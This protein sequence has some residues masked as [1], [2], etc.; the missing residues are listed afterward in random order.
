[1]KDPTQ[2]FADSA[3]LRRTSRIDRQ[4]LLAIDTWLQTLLDDGSPLLRQTHYFHGRYENLYI[5]G[6]DGT[7]GNGD[8]DELIAEGLDWS[9]QIFDTRPDQLR[10]GFWFNLMQPGQVTTLHRHDDFD[11]MLSGVV[12]LKVPEQSGDLVLVL[13]EREISLPPVMGDFVFFS[14]KTP[15]R[16]EQ[17]RSNSR[18]LSIGM[19][20]GP[21]QQSPAG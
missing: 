1:M 19:N 13:D 11:E 8:L 2:V 14:P 9:A 17:N 4:R 12:Y 20:I 7:T 18:R 16:V 15:H 21:A 3:Y 10:I 5:D 6:P